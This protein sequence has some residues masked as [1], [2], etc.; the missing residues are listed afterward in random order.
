M[1]KIA[2]AFGQIS[3]GGRRGSAGA[4]ARSPSRV[5]TALSGAVIQT[6]LE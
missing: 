4:G 2:D 3:A 5:L 6:A 1:V